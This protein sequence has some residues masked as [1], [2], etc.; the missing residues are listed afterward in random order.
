AR[1]RRLLPG[2]LQRTRPRGA[3][4]SQGGAGRDDRPRYGGDGEDAGRD[5]ES[6]FP[7]EISD[8]TINPEGVLFPHGRR[9]RPPTDLERKQMSHELEIK[10]GVAS[11]IWRGQKPWHEHGIEITDN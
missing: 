9:R 10:N 2:L 5:R 7:A 1:R 8:C 11:M 4:A 6:S 3:G